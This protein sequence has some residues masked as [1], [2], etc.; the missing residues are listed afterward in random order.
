MILLVEIIIAD[1]T[2]LRSRVFFS[3]IP[4][5]PFLVNPWVSGD[6][7]AV[8]LRDLGWRWGFGMFCILY[9]VCTLPLIVTLWWITR[10]ARKSGDL[11]AI[12]SPRQLYGGWKL[13]K[14]L[15][16]QLDFIG[17]I[18]TSIMLGFILT[19]LTIAGGISAR[20][21]KVEIILPLVIGLVAIPVW[22]WWEKKAPHPMIPFRVRLTMMANI[23]KLTPLSFSKT[24]PCGGPLVSP[25]LSI[26]VSTDAYFFPL[27]D[28]DQAELFTSFNCQADYLYTVLVVAFDETPK[29]ATRIQMLYSFV[30]VILGVFLGLIVYRVRRLKPFILFGTLLWMIGFGLLIHFRGGYD[31]SAHAGIVGAQILLGIGGG[32]FPY[33]AQASIQAATKHEHVAAVTG[34]Y[35]SSY[36]IGAALGN[37][38]SGAVWNNVMPKQLTLRLGDK[39]VPWFSSPLDVV[40][41][42]PVGTEEREAAIQ[43]T[44]YVQHLMC[45]MG[46]CAVGVIAMFSFVIR[47]P[48]L[49]DTQ[50]MPDAEQTVTEPEAF[51]PLE[52]L[53][54]PPFRAEMPEGVTERGWAWLKS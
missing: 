53:N 12:K 2:S 45:I 40:I 46:I 27:H 4:A 51:I 8:V 9:P 52:D 19:P 41:G 32:F 48:K 29:S 16:W 43:A 54:R 33:P 5:L 25:S 22:I 20:W 14:A 1:T 21:S 38:M 36:S 34:L 39:G 7:V 24:V 13:A 42:F 18:L 28:T 23:S 47:N 11:M 49:P 37:T 6:V 15:F 26:L 44:M 50:S 17:I 3:Y 35:L 10:K 30:S 31:D